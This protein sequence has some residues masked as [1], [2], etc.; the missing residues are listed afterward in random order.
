LIQL[1]SSLLDKCYFATSLGFNDTGALSSS[2]FF[3]K[4][5]RETVISLTPRE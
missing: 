1:F 2:V 5:Q 4:K 3:I